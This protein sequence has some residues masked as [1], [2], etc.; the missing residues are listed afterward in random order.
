MTIIIDGSLGVTSPGGDTQAADTTINGVR[1]G[2]GAGAVATNTAAGASA[3]AANTTGTNNTA[4]G[5]QAG[6]SNTTGT[7]ITVF[8]YKA[9]YATTGSYNTY[10][11]S[12]AG[13]TNTSGVNNTAIGWG[14]I[15]STSTASNNTAVGYGA[16]SNVTTGSNNTYLGYS[17]TGSVA[18]PTGEIVI[19]YGVA[20][21]GG[22]FKITLGSNGVGKIY[23]DYSTSATW[24]FSSD[25]NKKQHIQN[26]TLGLS[27]IN[28]LRT[29]T[30]QWKP[31]NELPTT[32]SDYA[33]ENVKDT[34]TVMHGLIAQEVKAAL[35]AEN[36]STFEGWGE[37]GDGSQVVS[38]EM[39]IIPLIK[40]I[41]E[42]QAIITALT[43]RITALEA[44]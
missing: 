30:Y 42:Q 3:L 19:G 24:T 35:D 36:I 15:S 33:E 5:Y 11:G 26:D 32:F 25:V 17:A 18:A 21:I 7:E 6:Y 10:F 43:T 31:N 44:A 1:V 14:A 22:N 41:Q 39:F 4:A 9:G 40:A 12:Q 38:R 28:R 20:G 27:F 37:A 16:G 34:T 2:R 13:V 8:G 29:V 23:A